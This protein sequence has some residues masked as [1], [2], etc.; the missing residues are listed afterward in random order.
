VPA[1]KKFYGVSVS[2]RG[3]VQFTEQEIKAGPGLTIGDDS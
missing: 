3:T 1:G 2:H